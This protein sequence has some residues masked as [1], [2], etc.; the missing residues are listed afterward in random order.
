[1]G[2]VPPFAGVAVNVTLV[3]A[4]IEVEEALM[5]TDAVT[6]LAETV[7]TLLVAFAVEVQLA[8]DVNITLTLSPFASVLDVNVVAFVPAFAPLISH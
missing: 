6:P 8:L 2:A 7:M 5:E 3:P 1:M 4:Q